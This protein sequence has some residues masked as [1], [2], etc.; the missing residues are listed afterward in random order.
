MDPLGWRACHVSGNSPGKATGVGC[1]SCLPGD[2]PDSRPHA[3]QADTLSEPQ[4]KP[5]VKTDLRKETAPKCGGCQFCYM[6]KIHVTCATISD[7]RR[8]HSTVQPSHLLPHHP[9]GHLGPILQSPFVS[10]SSPV[11]FWQ[12]HHSGH[13]ICPGSHIV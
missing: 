4:G 12:I 2:L 8:F 3:L 1:I 7:A 11:L 6:I 13:F 10:V 5:G 9:K